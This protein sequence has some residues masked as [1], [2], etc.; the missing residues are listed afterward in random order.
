[1]HRP[2]QID[3]DAVAAGYDSQP[4]R[5]RS[6]DR[7]FVA[8][9]AG[10][11]PGAD[12]AVLDL[13]CGTGNQLVANRAA[14]PTATMVGADRSLGMLR[15]ARGKTAGIAWVQADAAALPFAAGS[16]DFVGSQ[17]MFHH[18]PDKESML[19]EMLRVLRPG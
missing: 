12:V 8:F 9:L 10:R 3:Y 11:S 17:F 19:A 16:F 1:M 18:V 5:A 2:R 14:A 4:Y 13:G 7:E 15:Q 6:V